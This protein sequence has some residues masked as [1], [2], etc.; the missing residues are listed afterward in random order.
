MRAVQFG[1]SCRPANGAG[2]HGRARL[3]RYPSDLARHE[4][5]IVLLAAYNIGKERIF[6][7][8]ARQ[9]DTK[10]CVTAKK[11]SIMQLL[12]WPVA[13]GNAP[14]PRLE[15]DNGGEAGAP[16]AATGAGSH[17]VVGAPQLEDVFTTDVTATRVHAVPWNWLGETWPFFQPAFD[18]VELF[19][20]RCA[21]WHTCAC[22][23]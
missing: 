7:E 14:L 1:A 12:D 8:V 18:N 15:P 6:S 3:C 23:P 2:A 4:C 10:I 16:G 20:S 22:A 19:A 5:R 13:C 17:P 11:L 9:C 21:P